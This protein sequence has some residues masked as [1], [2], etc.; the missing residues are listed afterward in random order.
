M[1]IVKR[2]HGLIAVV[3]VVAICYPQ[4]ACPNQDRARVRLTENSDWWSGLRNIEDEYS[5]KPQEREV[6]ASNFKVAGIQLGQEFFE[7][8]IKSLGRTTIVVRGD[9]AGGREQACFVSGERNPKTHLIFE[10]GEV[11][12]S[13][14]LFAGGKTWTGEEHCLS[15]AKVSSSL[16]TVCG[17]RLGL[18]P[19]QV[20]A[21]L[22]T[23]SEQ[24]KDELTYSLHISKKYTEEELRAVRKNHPGVSEEELRKVYGYYDWSAGFDCKFENS[25]LTY[26]AVSLA[27]TT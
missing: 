17:L 5:G 24:R 8:A 27:E 18:S 20:I 14:Y 10:Q 7:Q 22:G 3:I 1:K 4:S 15:S 9:A 2:K 16:S 25:K 19:K 21:I 11:N 26:L 12:Y 23:P 13:F 6:P